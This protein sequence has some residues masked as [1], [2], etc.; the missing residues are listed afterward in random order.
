MSTD[1][2][3]PAYTTLKTYALLSASG[4]TSPV[5]TYT[6]TISN[7]KYGSYPVVN[8]TGGFTGTLDSGPN[9]LL[10]QNQLTVLIGAINGVTGV[11][12]YNILPPLISGTRTFPTGKYTLGQITL[13]NESL[14]F[15]A[16]G[17]P[18]A[19]FFII[20]T[21]NITFNNIPSITLI[22]K[23]SNCNIFWLAV[24][25]ITF[26]NTPDIS[27]IF[28]AG[29]GITFATNTNVRGH[30]YTTGSSITFAGINN[31]V[32]GQCFIVC[33]AENT[34]ILTK[35]GYIPIQHI[36]AE[37]KIVTK[38]KI[39]ESK[40]IEREPI[41]LDRVIWISKFKVNNMNE[42]SRPICIKKHALRFNSPFQ[43]LYV[44]PNHSVFINGKMT[45]AKSLV[46]GKTIYQDNECNEVT[47]YHLECK[48]HV[49]IIANGVLA[50][51]YLDCDNRHVF[52][53]T[54]RLINDNTLLVK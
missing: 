51:S 43:D 14:V 11:T 28:I 44:S 31:T 26:N 34:L 35:N 39:H 20:G 42:E 4:G 53:K 38:G 48:E 40:Y 21:S 54:E 15:D 22:N 5:G 23:A 45:L 36:K 13:E 46:N 2:N 10:A 18:N 1:I 24:S 47:Y 49:A 32:N 29:S 52:E 41:K 30:L 6:T 50:E 3:A 12:G 27:G 16:N 25:N 17:N 33:Y 8:F 37:D 7:I 19:Q 9:S